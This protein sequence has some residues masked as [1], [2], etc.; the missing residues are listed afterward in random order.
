VKDSLLISKGYDLMG[1]RCCDVLHL[2]LVPYQQLSGDTDRA[3]PL[4]RDQGVQCDNLS[5]FDR[6]R[7]TTV[8]VDI[9]YPLDHGIA[10]IGPL[11]QN[12]RK[13]SAWVRRRPGTHDIVRKRPG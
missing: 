6:Q 7:V 9:W 4:L 12:P 8:P 1:F 3:N 10:E 13:G 2:T 5:P 11:P